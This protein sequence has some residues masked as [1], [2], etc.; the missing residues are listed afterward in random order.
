M[1]YQNHRTIYRTARRFSGWL[2]LLASV[3]IFSGAHAQVTDFAGYNPNMNGAVYAM[4]LQADGKAL[5]GGAYTTVNGQTQPGIVR[6][7]ATGQA[8]SGF[9]ALT[10]SGSAVEA[11]AVQ[12]DGQVLIGGTFTT[13]DGTAKSYLARLHIDGTLDTGFATGA[14]ANGDVSAIALQPDG[15]IL[16]GG[17]FTTYAGVAR[18]HIARLFADGSLDSTFSTASLGVVSG[19]P[20]IEKFV[21]LPNGTV[22][23]GGRFD[24]IGGTTRVGIARLYST[25][26]LDPNFN[27]QLSSV[28]SVYAMVVQA[29]GSLVLGGEFTAVLGTA[30]NRIARVLANGTLDSGFVIGTGPNAFVHAIGLRAN[31]ALVIGGNFTAYAGASYSRIVGLNSD[32]S[33][34]TSFVI[35]SGTSSNLLR[36]IAVQSDGNVLIGGDFVTV[37]GITRNHLARVF[38][39][40]LLDSGFAS[41]FASGDGA[42]A[43]NVQTNGTIVIGG[44]FSTIGGQPRKNIVRLLANGTLDSSFTPGTGADSVISTLATQTDGRVLL[45]GYFANYNGTARGGIARANYD[46]T[47][48]TVF[49]PSSGVNG[50]MY[51]LLL[52]ADGKVLLFGGFTMVNG[53]PRQNLARMNS[54]GSLDATFTADLAGFAYLQSIALQAGGKIVI[55]GRCDDA[56]CSVPSN[57]VARLNSDGTPDNTFTVTTGVLSPGQ[58]FLSGMVVQPDGR[59]VI[60][61]DF[62]SYAGQPR[63]RAARLMS[64]GA[65]DASFDPGSLLSDNVSALAL[66]ANGRVI[67]GG[68][69]TTLN[70]STQSYLARMNSDGSVDTSFTDDGIGG[71]PGGFSLQTD[72]RLLVNGGFAFSGGHSYNKITR[73]IL[74]EPATQSLT[75]SANG[76]VFTWLRDGSSPE[77]A[78]PPVLT[79]SYRPSGGLAVSG[80]IGTMQRI[81]GGWQ[82][83]RSTPI[84]L[85][86][87]FFLN[88]TAYAP[89]ASGFGTVSQQ[90]IQGSARV[91][92][93]DRIF[94][95][96]FQ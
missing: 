40:G 45:G 51:G 7:L 69:F 92:T 55:G 82:I 67:V 31:G 54:D 35:G 59:I 8:D 6:L 80:T 16:I 49:A 75:V 91:I 12:V 41:P 88:A 22:L 53:Q 11:V 18:N 20:T 33:V 79:Y 66:Q 63:M 81:A 23:V 90:V 85:D 64:D 5:I 48:D 73:K 68:N 72:G 87:Y 24:S 43:V 58:Q 61:G 26:V 34:D 9:A 78:L 37:G 19:V 29:D 94:S 28:A 21:V 44:F 36:T 86:G 89:A 57:R 95:G 60:G 4:A 56:I 77:L 14:T 32:G 27:L 39:T 62:L 50:Q 2:C 52:Q 76:T 74:P 93:I 10:N 13:V 96:G 83:S 46:G 47:L 42:S 17:S 84:R 30:I 70:G 38:A 65:F 3:L 25:G 1:S 15:K 71:T